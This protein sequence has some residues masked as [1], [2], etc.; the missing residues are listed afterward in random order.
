M[1]KKKEVDTLVLRIEQIHR[2][3]PRSKKCKKKKKKRNERRITA[4]SNCIGN[5]RTHIQ[6]T[7]FG[8]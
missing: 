5:I 4:V 1:N 8:K 3:T 6:K 2:S 7:K